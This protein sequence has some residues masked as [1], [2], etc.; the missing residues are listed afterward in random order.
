M[1]RYL[2]TIE[3]TKHYSKMSTEMKVARAQAGA[4][5]QNDCEYTKLY[6]VMDEEGTCNSRGESTAS[7]HSGNHRKWWDGTLQR[8]KVKANFFFE[9]SAETLNLN[10]KQPMFD[11]YSIVLP[12]VCHPEA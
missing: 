1:H 10:H 9:P 3:S 8:N 11:S 5:G 12:A 2:V 6:D 7:N 4:E